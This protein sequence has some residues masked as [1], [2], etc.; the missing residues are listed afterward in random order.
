MDRGLSSDEK[1]ALQ[2]WM[3]DSPEN[4][5]T[6]M[7]MTQLWDKMDA[8]TRLSDLF[9]KPTRHA[10]QTQT[11]RSNLIE[12][13]IEHWTKSW[14][15]PLPAMAASIALATVLGL[16]AILGNVDNNNNSYQTAIGEQSTVMLPDGTKMTLN[17]NTSVTVAY[18]D[19]QHLL[20]LTQGEL[21]V[22]VAKDKN[23]PL[24]VMAGGKV[25]QAIGTEFNIEI[26]SQQKIELVVTEGKVKVGIQQKPEKQIASIE[27]L[28]LPRD[29]LTVSAGEEIML[30]EAKEQI[31]EVSAE[32]IAVKLSWQKGN[33]IFR[34]ESLEEAV[35]EVGRYTSVEFVFMDENL[36]K[37][38]VAGLYKA[39]DVQGLLATL[40]ENFDIVSQ[41]DGNGKVLL[42]GKK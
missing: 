18:S 42:S 11:Q 9:P 35:R 29:A 19:Q 33:L 8:M 38:R 23:R 21:H 37:M 13:L 27:P 39:G 28:T 25:I 32:D 4:H 10:S 20:H 5:S 31:T 16:W 40:R 14:L 2:E 6:L 34:G 41:R 3:Q 1:I 15:K 12:N 24:S 17:T 30:G 7:Q 22:S 36:K 26:T